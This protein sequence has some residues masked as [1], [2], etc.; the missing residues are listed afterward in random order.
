MLQHGRALYYVLAASL[1]VVVLVT[2]RQLPPVVASHF[3]AAGAPNGWSS[4]PVYGLVL[5][6][7]GILL[8]LGTTALVGALTRSGPAL[9]NIPERDYWARPE[10]GLEAVRRVR[11]YV[12]WLACILAATALLVHLLVLAAHAHQPPRL[13]ASALVL[14][15][16]AVFVAVA[17]WTVGWYRL[18]RRPRF[19]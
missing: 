9:L 16:G 12:W 18:L 6:G 10:H 5:F 14:V 8:P 17:G 19:G 13:S 3:D 11:A 7:I 2:L 4:R 1:I 15:L